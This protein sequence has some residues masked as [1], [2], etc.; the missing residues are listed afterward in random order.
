MLLPCHLQL[1]SRFGWSLSNLVVLLRMNLFSYRDLYSWL[2][3]PFGT[4]PD[5]ASVRQAALALA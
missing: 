5:E 3:E 4:P 1:K 2:D